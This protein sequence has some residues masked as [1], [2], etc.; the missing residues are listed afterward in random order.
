MHTWGPAASGAEPPHGRGPPRP[1]PSR[2]PGAGFRRP[3]SVGRVT[4]LRHRKASW[5]FGPRWAFILE[6]VRAPSGLLT[7]ARAPS[8]PFGAGAV[9]CFVFYRQG[10]ESAFVAVSLV[11]EVKPERARR[12][13]TASLFPGVG[14]LL[15][16]SEF[17]SHQPLCCPHLPPHERNP[18]V[19]EERD[20]PPGSGLGP[21]GTR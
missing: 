19:W 13:C 6:A 9:V 11:R 8:V 14:G 15:V 16:T 21:A 17:R 4:H 2:D 12:P 10:A 7:A 3:C 18:D 5:K 1:H 20:A